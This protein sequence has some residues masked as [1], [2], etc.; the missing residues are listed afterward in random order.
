[1]MARRLYFFWMMVAY[2]CVAYA[3]PSFYSQRLKCIA[4]AVGV[5]LP[6]TLQPEKEYAGIWTFKQRPLRV[7]TNAF[8]D[9]SHI[10]YCLFDECMYTHYECKTVLDFAERYA[11][12]LTLGKDE[13]LRQ[14]LRITDKVTCVE[15]SLSML[16]DISPRTPVTIDQRQLRMFRIQWTLDAKTILTL[17]FPADY[18]LI[19]GVNAIELEKIFERDVQRIVSMAQDDMLINWKNVPVVL[20]GD[21]VAQDVLDEKQNMFAGSKDPI[22]YVA[23]APDGLLLANRGSYLNSQIR[24]DVTLV[25]KKGER[26]LHFSAESPISSVRNLLLT[27]QFPTIVP[28]K[29]TIDCYGNK[30]QNLEKV[31]LQQFVGLCRME[32]CELYVGIKKRTDT[33]VSATVFAVNRSMAYNHVLSVD[34]P[35][36]VF[37][38]EKVAISGT[39]Y[40]YI[41]LQNVD[42][43]FFTQDL[44]N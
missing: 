40:T 28:L 15:G 11:L 42:E 24:S 19:S 18:Q 30:K 26:M 13:E 2:V 6:D 43:K 39:L 37:Q 35:L 12:E 3:S 32:G 41:P 44:N 8:G 33:E 23:D 36:R 7:R 31:S 20:L 14:R 4:Q 34:V 16:A 22:T 1:M 17:S 5:Q 29:L 21:V 10:G 27:G 38:D 25:Q 9:V